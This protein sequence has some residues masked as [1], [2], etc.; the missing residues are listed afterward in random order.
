MNT[1]AVVLIIVG[2]WIRWLAIRK[3]SALSIHQPLGG[4]PHVLVTDG[5]YKYLRHPGY[6]GSMLITVGLSILSIHLTIWLLTGSFLVMHAMEEERVIE[7]AGFPYASY[8]VRT[9]MFIP[10]LR[11]RAKD[12]QVFGGLHPE[13]E[14]I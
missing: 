13:D 1:L 8:K 6:V 7:D 4:V 3:N 10:K 5:V 2:G 12:C 11:S 14:V 9:G